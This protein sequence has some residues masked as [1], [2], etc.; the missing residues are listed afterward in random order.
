MLKSIG[1]FGKS[2]RFAVNFVNSFTYYAAVMELIS[3]EKDVASGLQDPTLPE[4]VKAQALLDKVEIQTQ[5]SAL[6]SMTGSNNF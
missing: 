1:P 3:W 4:D 6:R 2:E 5:F